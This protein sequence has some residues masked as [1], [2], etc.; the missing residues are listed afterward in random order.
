MAPSA[1]WRSRSARLPRRR[2]PRAGSADRSRANFVP[3]RPSTQDGSAPL[4]P[5]DGLHRFL[6]VGPGQ[7]AVALG[8][9]HLVPGARELEHL[10]RELI[11][12]L[13]VA[14]AGVVGENLE[15]RL[16]RRQ[17]LADG[18]ELEL[19]LLLAVDAG[20]CGFLSLS[21]LAGDLR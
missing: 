15:L 2:G 16:D 6:P 21:G 5:A 12:R 20:Q 1:S 7:L 9:L 8:R 18:V 13:L 14:D 10:G 17:A 4:D 11:E 19:E 3:A